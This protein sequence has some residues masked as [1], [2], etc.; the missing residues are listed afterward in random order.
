MSTYKAQIR[1]ESILAHNLF[2][3]LEYEAMILKCNGFT[4]M[5]E[6]SE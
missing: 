2:K 3:F 4:V 5:I 1:K 6:M